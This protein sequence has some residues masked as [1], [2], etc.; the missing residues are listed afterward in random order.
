MSKDVIRDINHI[1]EQNH[2]SVALTQAATM[3]QSS[4]SSYQ[5]LLVELQARLATRI[6]DR[7]D[8]AVEAF[9]VRLKALEAETPLGSDDAAPP[10]DP[11]RRAI[12]KMGAVPCKRPHPK[13]RPKDGRSGEDQF[14]A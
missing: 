10:A 3:G 14:F 1:N 6:R 11:D 4:A 13:M 8:Y 5:G 7:V 9:S 12:G 2:R